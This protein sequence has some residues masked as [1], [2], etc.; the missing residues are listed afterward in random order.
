MGTLAYNSGQVPPRYQVDQ[1]SFSMEA[2]VI[3]NGSYGDIRKGRLGGKAVAVRTLRIDQQT[4]HDEALKVC[5]A[6][7]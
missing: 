5:V 1:K 2:G 7:N 3:S 4:G 6:S